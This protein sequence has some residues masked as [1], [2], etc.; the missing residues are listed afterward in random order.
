MNIKK[1]T[2]QEIEDELVGEI[3]S[4]IDSYGYKSENVFPLLLGLFVT[5]GAYLGKSKGEI[6]TNVSRAY[7]NL[8]ECERD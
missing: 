5:L 2:P 1:H 6:I 8:K 3:C 4:V 7:D